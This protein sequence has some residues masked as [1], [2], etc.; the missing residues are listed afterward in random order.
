VTIFTK[1]A[2][3]LPHARAIA[4]SKAVGKCVI[5]ET[6]GLEAWKMKMEGMCGLD[7][8]SSH[9]NNESVNESGKGREREYRKGG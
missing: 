5:K 9:E 3:R 8:N 2:K 4:R 1:L 6:A 7:I